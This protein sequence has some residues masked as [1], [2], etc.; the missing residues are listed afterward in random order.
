MCLTIYVSPS[1]GSFEQSVALRPDDGRD[2][3]EEDEEGGK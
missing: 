2:D 1:C 3:E